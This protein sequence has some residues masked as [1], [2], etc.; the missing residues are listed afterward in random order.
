MSEPT[1]VSVLPPV[2]AIVLAISTRQV[3]L[4]LAGGIWFGATVLAGWNPIA[5]LAG[6]IDRM[7]AVLMSEGD[8]KVIL[9]TLVIGALVRTVETS[10]GVKGFVAWLE[11]LQ[12]VD[13]PRR[14]QVLA[15]SLGVIVFI[16]SNISVL[17]AGTVARPLFDRYKVS[18][19][20]LS[21]IIDSTSAPVC[22]L[23]PLN[24]WGAYTLGLLDGLGVEEPLEVFLGAVAVNFY[25]IAAVL[26]AVA[27]I[28]WKIDLGPMKAAEARVA[29]GV[30]HLPGSQPL[31]D[32]ESMEA[33]PTVAI[34]PRA[35]NMLVPLGVMVFAMPLFL[36]I[37]GDGDILRGSGS[38]SVLWAVLAGLATAW[39]MLLAQRALSV[40]RLTHHALQGAGSLLPL[41]LILMLA[42]A[43]GGTAKDLGTG[44]Y[45]AQ[46]AAGRLAPVILVPLIFAV[47]SGI[48]FAI[49]T[50]WGTFAIML[51]IAVPTATAMGLPL[52][53]FVA[54]SLAGGVFGDHA[55]PISDTTVVSSMAAATDHIEHVRTQLPYAL[56]AA[57]VALVGFAILGA[58]L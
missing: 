27:T 26:L 11:K 7:V 28:V 20:K 22:I 41:A 9:F 23:I 17:V 29:G 34:E 18:R 40:N 57:G 36:F 32:T 45:V 56:L 14:A 47:A 24:A 42:L 49:G 31:M 21:Y 58:T 38:T 12:W 39:F 35:R 3:Y 53:P 43:L 13:S 19:E 46:L 10:G 30:M 50:S 48:A 52:E 25:A 44:P 54:A 51:P 33:D 6:A 16:E 37:T 55:S 2:L 15:W 1:F 8:A 5:G 4:S